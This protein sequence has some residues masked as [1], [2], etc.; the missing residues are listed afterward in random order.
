MSTETVKGWERGRAFCVLYLYRGVRRHE[1]FLRR[2]PIARSCR[3]CEVIFAEPV[4]RPK[5]RDDSTDH[6][7]EIDL[8]IDLKDTATLKPFI[9][10]LEVPDFPM[11]DLS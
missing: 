3:P 11:G 8:N 9:E 10:D 1:G 7:T 4:G 6:L 5:L 2:T